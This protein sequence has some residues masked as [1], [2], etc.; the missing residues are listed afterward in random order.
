[1]ANAWL[2]EVPT[3]AG[4]LLLLLSVLLIIATIP[5]VLALTLLDRK[6]Q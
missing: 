4:I 5:V 1:M 3:L 2:V 6:D